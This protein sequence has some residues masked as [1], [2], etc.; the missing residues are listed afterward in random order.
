MLQGKKLWIGMALLAFSLSMVVI[1]LTGCK[2]TTPTDSNTTAAAE[3]E[4]TT[5]PVMGKPIN[6]DLFVEYQDK[7]V[8]FCCKGCKEKFQQEPEKYLDKLPQFK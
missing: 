3:T 1:A 7:K 8:Y 2:Q 5:C 4:Q 6:K